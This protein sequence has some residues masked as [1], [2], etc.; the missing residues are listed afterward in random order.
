METARPVDR[1]RE[2]LGNDRPH[3]IIEEIAMH[4]DYPQ[5]HFHARM[6]DLTQEKQARRALVHGLAELCSSFETL[7]VWMEV[8]GYPEEDILAV[9]VAAY[10]AV[11]NAFQHGNQR[12]PNKFIDFH[13]LVTRDEMWLQVEDQ[14]PGFDPDRVPDPP[15]LQ[16]LAA[17]HG[18]G[19][20]Q[21]RA[22]MTWVRF[23]QKGNRVTL[24]KQRS[25]PPSLRG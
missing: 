15:A 1:H 6:V 18:C 20:C 10:E 13:Y 21:M 12:D 5:R 11:S 4:P 17:P 24:Y 25:D 3:P 23:N 19:L 16:P 14:G 9:R 8:L 7:E 2:E 22:C